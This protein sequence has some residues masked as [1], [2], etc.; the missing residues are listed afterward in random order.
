MNGVSCKL[1]LDRLGKGDAE[2][3][4]CLYVK[5]LPPS[6]PDCDQCVMIVQYSQ[7]KMNIGLTFTSS[8]TIFKD[9]D[10]VT[11]L[12]YYQKNVL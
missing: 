4:F 10:F 6:A 11:V 3:R 7:N 2:M 1:Q 5:N 9:E 12:A 8:N